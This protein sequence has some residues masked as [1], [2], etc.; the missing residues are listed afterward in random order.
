MVF[1]HISA[2]FIHSFHWH[3]QNSTI[4]CHS[5]EL[6]PF[7]SVMYFFLP[8]FPTNYS[9]I[10]S[11]PTLLSISWSTSQSCCSQI[12]IFLTLQNSVILKI[13]AA[14][15][16]E[17]PHFKHY[18]VQKPKRRLSSDQQP[19]WKPENSKPRGTSS[20]STDWHLKTNAVYYYHYSFHLHLWLILHFGFH[21][22]SSMISW[23]TLYSLRLIEWLRTLH[24]DLFN[25]GKVFTWLHWGRNQNGDRKIKALRN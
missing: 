24:P 19:P 15:S 8:P 11:H 2:P 4:P 9:S 21:G 13:E 18:M 22:N 3:V 1:F 5:Q 14:C 7:L 16:S 23:Q 25:M 6:L 10:L 20:F 12:H 17:M